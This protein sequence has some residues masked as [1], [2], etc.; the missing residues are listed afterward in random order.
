MTLD[1]PPLT[2]DGDEWQSIISQQGGENQIFH[3]MVIARDLLW[4]AEEAMRTK[5]RRNFTIAT[6]LRKP[7]IQV[8][9]QQYNATEKVRARKKKIGQKM[10]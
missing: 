2:V 1:R 4:T 5:I 6:R 3:D 10:A 7:E 8:A 9:R